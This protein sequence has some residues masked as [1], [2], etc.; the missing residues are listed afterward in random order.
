MNLAEV[1]STIKRNEFTFLGEKLMLVSICISENA[2]ALHLAH[3]QLQQELLHS[4]TACVN[5]IF[6]V[7]W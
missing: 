6:A 4:L 2:C 1:K 7:L 5:E 3:S